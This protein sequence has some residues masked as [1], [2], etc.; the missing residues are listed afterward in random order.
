MIIIKI[1]DEINSYIL[2]EKFD[3]MNEIKIR[4]CF[5]G[6][7]DNVDG[8]KCIFGDSDHWINNCGLL[9]L[10]I[11]LEREKIKYTPDKFVVFRK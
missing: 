6:S 1:C 9:E 5:G 11:L 2:N 10:N 3:E 7:I 4:L 8:F